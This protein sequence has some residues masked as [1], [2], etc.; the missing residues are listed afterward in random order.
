[1][2]TCHCREYKK[3]KL[4]RFLILDP[5]ENAPQICSWNGVIDAKKQKGA[6]P[7]RWWRT[8]II[9]EDMNNIRVQLEYAIAIWPKKNK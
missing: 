2:G 4:C 7:Y 6:H 9:R 3:A 8:K 1:M 5:D